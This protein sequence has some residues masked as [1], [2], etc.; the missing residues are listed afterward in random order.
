MEKTD[1]GKDPPPS[2]NQVCIPPG[3]V[4]ESQQLIIRQILT[5]PGWALSPSDGHRCHRS[6][7]FSPPSKPAYRPPGLRGSA[8]HNPPHPGGGCMST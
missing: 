8:S 4:Q 2:P 7:V 1:F 5:F 3:P 6:S